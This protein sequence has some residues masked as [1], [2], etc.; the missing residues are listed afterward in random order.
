MQHFVGRT[1]EHRVLFTTWEEGLALWHRLVRALPGLR[2]LVLMPDHFHA[3]HPSDRRW[4][5]GVAMRSFARWRGTRLRDARPLWRPQPEPV[6]I[7]DRLHLQRTE[8]YLALNPSRAELVEDPLAWPLSSYRDAVGLS[9][10]P[11]RRPVEDPHAFHHYVSS[12]PTVR[13]TGTGLPIERGSIPTLDEVCEAVSAVMRVTLQALY[14]RGPT[15][16]VAIRCM[17]TLCDASGSDIAAHLGVSR[18]T[19]SRVRAGVDRTVRLV[20]VVAGDRRFRGLTDE[21]LRLLPGW[22][23]YRGRS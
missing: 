23:R 12:D 1:I 3:L 22:W 5:L 20:A 7:P 18:A 9:A 10:Q 19:V 4:D 6:A 8:R 2:Q 13:T 11:V 17:K 16:T 21:D 15:R 14:K